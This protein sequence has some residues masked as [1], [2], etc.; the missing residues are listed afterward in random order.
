MAGYNVRK[1]CLHINSDKCDE[2]KLNFDPQEDEQHM[3][4][5]EQ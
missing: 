2:I 4:R 3:N 1:H 5:Q